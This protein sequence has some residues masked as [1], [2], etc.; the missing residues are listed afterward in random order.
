MCAPIAAEA[1]D[2]FGYAVALGECEKGLAEIRAVE[3]LPH[4]DQGSPTDEAWWVDVG[5]SVSIPIPK[6]G[7]ALSFPYAGS[8]SFRMVISGGAALVIIDDFRAGML[9]DPMDGALSP[10][11]HALRWLGGDWKLPECDSRRDFVD[12]GLLQVFLHLLGSGE[13]PA[14]AVLEGEILIARSRF[15]DRTQWSV[16]RPGSDESPGFSATWTVKGDATAWRP[17]PVSPR[18]SESALPEWVE[19]F[20]DA[21]A[22]RDV[23]NLIAIGAEQGWECRKDNRRTPCSELATTTAGD[24]RAG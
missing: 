19:R 18:T 11:S 4:P 3:R 17:R 6:Q 15:G 5:G 16:F 7:D 24:K 10:A 22:R 13:M 1:F 2:P 23:P 8:G 14:V 21:L 12:V 9:S 20:A